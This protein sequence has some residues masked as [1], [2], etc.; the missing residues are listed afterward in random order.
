MK[1]LRRRFAN[2]A[3]EAAVRFNSGGLLPDGAWD[4]RR[5]ESLSESNPGIYALQWKTEQ[6]IHGLAIKEV[7]GALTKI[8][9][10]TGKSAATLD[11]AGRDGWQEVAEYRQQR[12]DVGNGYGLGVMNPAARYVDGYVDFGRPIKTLAVRLRVVEQWADKGKAGCMGIRM[13][14]G[15]GTLDSK[16]CRVFGVAALQYLGGEAP[17][18]PLSNERIEVYDTRNGS[19]LDEITIARP[20]QL[21]VGAGGELLAFSGA[22]VVRVDPAGK[23]HQA[24]VSDLQSP[25][26]LAA[27]REGQMYV[28]DA[29]K[30]RQNVRVY[31]RA[32][33]YVRSI[34]TPG[35][36]HVGPWDPTRMGAVT[37][38]DVDRRGQ[39]WVVE[40][41][42]WPKRI[43]LWDA[44][45]TFKKEFLGNT[46]YGGGGVLDPADKT[47]L[48]YGPLEFAIDWS[49]GASR[50]K[51][52]TLGPG[53][54]SLELAGEVP[55]RAGGRTYLVNRTNVL[56]MHCGVVYLYEK[57]HLKP[58][59]AM[60]LALYFDPLKRP[61][62]L[63][64]LSTNLADQKFIWCDRNG[65]G[66]VQPEEVILSPKPAAMHGLTNFNRDLGVQAGSLRYEVREFLPNGAPVY[67]EREMP[68]LRGPYL[69]RLDDGNFYRM[70][71]DETTDTKVDPEGRRIWS[72]PQEGWG[73]GALHHARPFRPD[74]VVAQFGMAGHETAHAGGL[75]EFFVTLTNPGAWNLWTADGLLAG[76]IFR[77]LR[78]PKAQ[79]WS[80][81]AHQRGMILENVTAG[82]EHFQG[83]FCRTADD[84]YYVVAGHN[85]ISIL[86]VLGLD[87]CRRLGGELA[88][89]AEEVRKAQQW[90]ARRE[91]EEVYQRAPVVDVYRLRKP[92]QLDGKLDDWGPPD[93]ELPEGAELRLGYDDGFL[94]VAC[95][96]RSLGPLANRGHE[97]DRLF[98]TGAAVYLQIGTDAAAGEDR[99]MPQA[100]DARLLMT[101]VDG[102]P[103]A[104]LYRP[105]VPG[106]PPEKAWRVVSPV[107]QT[108]IDEVKRLEDVRMVHVGGPNQYL[109]E[110][111]VPLAALGLKPEPGLRLKLDWGILVSGPAGSEVLRRVYWANHASQISADAPSEARLQPNLWGHAR[112]HE[113]R[114]SAE[115]ELGEI[116]WPADKNAAKKIQKDV[117]DTL[118]DSPPASKR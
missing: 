27:D 89:S 7:D 42:Y 36:F 74:Q 50:L 65:D 2:V 111:A 93:A 94:Y 76:P 90:D 33:K 68:G 12:R 100:G 70:G 106:T 88:L 64:R 24:L 8:D 83:W 41:Q 102:R 39:L 87:R 51:N 84:H 52:L 67:A 79:P 46:A 109:L 78:D 86:E 95:S 14:L 34:G 9:V 91:H 54:N 110:A 61:E 92:P 81:T 63:S 47:R 107:G 16:R 4:A 108:T 3:G 15:G 66:Q 57:D 48:F 20:G 10:F 1:L 53:W 73:V 105:V 5:T 49:C 118:D 117:I 101:R 21:A 17:V 40:N 80:M 29:G 26:A 11:I 23:A 113:Y 55:L 32:G 19:L 37:S 44:G 112:F 77:D 71:A 45:G 115:E 98:K 59:A 75:G 114:P 58:V 97:W 30:D 69:Y 85:H 6:T 104:V 60:G 99:K 35:G 31:D 62:V 13:D 96:T 72:V 38:L 28:F 43:T 18:D 116:R 103:V 82:E 25:S 22:G 56:D